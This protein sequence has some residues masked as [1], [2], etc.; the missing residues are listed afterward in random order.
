MPGDA[1]CAVESPICAGVIDDSGKCAPCGLAQQACCPGQ[2]CN[3]SELICAGG[4][5]GAGTCVTCGGSNEICCPDHQCH[6]GLLC[7]IYYTCLSVTTPDANL[8]A[9]IDAEALDAGTD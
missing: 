2:A 9:T 8:D 6:P 1:C 5:S 4:L 7:S 3:T